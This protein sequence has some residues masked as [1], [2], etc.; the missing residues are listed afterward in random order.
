MKG[1]LSEILANISATKISR[2][3]VWVT[4]KITLWVLVGPLP[5]VSGA[6]GDVG[7]ECH[8][9]DAGVLLR[10]VLLWPEQ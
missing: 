9:G 8:F 10:F 3:W 1:E 6:A 5:W 2:L 4:S 7:G